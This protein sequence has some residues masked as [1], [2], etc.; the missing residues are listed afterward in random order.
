MTSTIPSG[1]HSTVGKQR[2]QDSEAWQRMEK[3]RASCGLAKQQWLRLFRAERERDLLETDG[4][5]KGCVWTQAQFVEEQ[6][7]VFADSVFEAL[8]REFARAPFL[9]D[10]QRL[11][12]AVQVA[13]VMGIGDFNVMALRVRGKIESVKAASTYGFT[14]ESIMRL[15][16]TDRPIGYHSPLAGSFLRHMED[17]GHIDPQPA[18]VPT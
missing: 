14:K 7:K 9:V 10:G 8:D 11:I 18:E 5:L 15:L 1:H 17:A 3:I 4:T 16:D 2:P 6:Y 12:T 13:R